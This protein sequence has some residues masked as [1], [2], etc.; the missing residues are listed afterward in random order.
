MSVLGI[1]VAARPRVRI[2]E[3]TLPEI[4][5]WTA[6]A[7]VANIAIW[8]LAPLLIEHSLRLDAAEGQIGG[9]FWQLNYPKHPPF[10]EWL[11]AI[12]KLAGPA[13]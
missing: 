12:C 2:G 9:P 11:I 7:A 6:V 3:R 5:F 4:A 8:S 13:R 1:E 10:W